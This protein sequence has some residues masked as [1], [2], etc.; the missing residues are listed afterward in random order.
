MAVDDVNQCSDLTDLGY[1]TLLSIKQPAA[2]LAISV[3]N[4]KGENCSYSNDGSFD[5]TVSGGA[6][7]EYQVYVDGDNG[8]DNGTT[9]GG[10][11]TFTGLAP[12][13]YVVTA[14]DVNGCSKS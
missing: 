7:P 12:G 6:L 8:S 4:V 2:D 13:N 5:V 3:S 14:L 9:V 1:W 10:S 11:Y